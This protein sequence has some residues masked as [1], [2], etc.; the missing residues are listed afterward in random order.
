MNYPKS[1][2]SFKGIKVTMTWMRDD[3]IEKLSPVTQIYAVVFSKR[4]EILVAREAEDG[5]WQIPGGK[6]EGNENFRETV[7]RELLEE[8]DVQAGEIY[9]LGAQKTE[10]PGNPNKEEG[11]IFYQLRCVVELGDLLPQT[12]D[13]DRG[14]VWQRKFVPAE[15]VA[16]YIK[17]GEVGNAMFADAIKL[18]KQKHQ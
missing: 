4:G 11:D 17:W 9:L 8:V 14:N 15:E 16:A 7:T 5:K 10:M 18:W 1:S 3:K 13:P 12:P 2:Y 6:S